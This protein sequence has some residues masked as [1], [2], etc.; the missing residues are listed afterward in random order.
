MANILENEYKAASLD[1]QKE[2]TIEQPTTQKST[3]NGEPRS[4]VYNKSS[5]VVIPYSVREDIYQ[6]CPIAYTSQMYLDSQDFIFKLQV[7][8]IL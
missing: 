3:I 7:D 6:T 1:Q 5:V 8:P 2:T 4:S